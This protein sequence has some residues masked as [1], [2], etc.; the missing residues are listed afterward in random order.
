[1]LYRNM[2]MKMDDVTLQYSIVVCF[3][4]NG[5]LLTDSVLERCKDTKC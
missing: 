2:V 4:S 1:M 5:T 3:N